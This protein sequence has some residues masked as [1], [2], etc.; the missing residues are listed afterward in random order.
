MSNIQKIYLIVKHFLKQKANFFVNTKKRRNTMDFLVPI[1]FFTMIVW[2]IKIIS[3]N[4][5]RRRAIE[6]GNV[7][8]SLKHLWKNYYANKPLQNIKWSII[9]GGTGIV[10]LLGHLFCLSQAV[11]AGT[12]LLVVSLALIV[13][14]L[15]ERKK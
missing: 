15:L 2:I 3:D 10:I 8:E 9:F 6:S 1:A 12:L 11:V 13:Y 4:R 14:Y 7:N 5:I